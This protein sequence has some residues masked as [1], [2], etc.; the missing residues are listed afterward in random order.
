MTTS[1]AV[2][3]RG[4]QKQYGRK[5][6]LAD[7]SIGVPTGAVCGVVGA[8][9]S[10]KTTLLKL[11][12]GLLRP[13]GGEARVCQRQPA[14]ERTFLETVGY[15][16][17]EVP[18]YGR[19]TADEHLR[20]GAH[21]NDTWDETMARERLLSLDIPL[22]QRVQ[23]LSGGM[24]AQVALALA[25]GKRPSVL[26]L[27]EPVAALDPLARREFLASLTAAVADG[28]VT[29]LMSSHL[30]PD[31]ERVCDHLVLLS[32]GSALVCAEIDELVASHKQVTAPRADA[33]RAARTMSVLSTSTTT[34]DVSLTVRIDHAIIDPSWRV[35]DL[36]LEEIVLAYL[37]GSSQRE[38]VGTAS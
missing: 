37:G 1:P 2:E 13:T 15:L 30:L 25:L 26:L 28:E 3:T 6:A 5:R 4:L 24:R 12:C 31:L 11:L 32:D 10:G 38:Q 16:G 23:T 18:L 27:D 22:D 8:N 19:W 35:D 21:T 14:D 17:Q 33:A 20:F 29:V 34:R 9:G 36:D 7:C